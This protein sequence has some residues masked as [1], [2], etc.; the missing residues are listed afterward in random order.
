VIDWQYTGNR[1]HPT[2][3]PINVLRPLIEAFC[4]RG[5]LVLDPFCGSGSTLIAAQQLGCAF[6]GCELDAAHQA[7]A[8]RRIS[9][10]VKRAA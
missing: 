8:A 6:V 1:L 5:G 2:Q 10:H 4:Q 9:A 7:T 3:K